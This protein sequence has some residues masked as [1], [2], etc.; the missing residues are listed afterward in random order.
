MAGGTYGAALDSYAQHAIKMRTRSAFEAAGGQE[1]QALQGLTRSQELENALAQELSS[2]DAGIQELASAQLAAA[3]ALD[4]ANA[5]EL[6]QAAENGGAVS[7]LEA[8]K[9]SLFQE[10]YGELSS[11]LEA[12]PALGARGVPSGNGTLEA[13]QARRSPLEAR[14]DPAAKLS[15][16]ST[17]AIDAIVDDA[18]KITGYAV[19][20]LTGIGL[21][22]FV[23]ALGDTADRLLSPL[24]DKAK[25]L[26]GIALKFVVKAVAKLLRLLGPFE[27]PAREWLG[28]KL[29]GVTRD[30]IVEFAVGRALGVDD[31]KSAV[32]Q[33]IDGANGSLDDDRAETAE[34]E[35]KSLADRFGRHELVIKVLA[36]LL[37]KVRSAVLALAAWAPAALA[38][39]Y[40]LV[41]S[42]GIWVAGDFLDWHR[43]T[44]DG[45][46]DRVGGVRTVVQ[47]A[48]AG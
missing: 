34:G 14:S 12:E 4:L 35:L 8:G 18:E 37:G 27:K 39:V 36:K 7:P 15:A 21:D 28:K 5:A 25:R 30:K 43:T 19:S 48:T 26:V 13:A 32:Q 9:T 47:L 2:G 45:A 41:L 42:Y 33:A 31:I 6:L 22:T 17:T 40:L 1:A 11:V 10:T 46:L 23:G 3:A 24:I 29:E 38:G 44:T 20:G 16:A